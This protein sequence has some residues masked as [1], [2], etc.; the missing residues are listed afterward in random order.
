MPFFE[1]DGRK[2]YY[3]I[4]GQGD[5]VVLIHG[6]ALDSRIWMDVPQYLSLKYAVLT[7]DLR[8]HGQSYAPSTGYSYRDHVSDLNLLITELGDQKATLIGHSLGGAVAVK[9]TLQH[10]QH[11]RSL[12]LAAPHIVGYK[13][14]TA[15]PNVFRTARQIDIDQAKIQWETFRLFQR[16]DKNSPDWEVLKSCISDFPGKVWTDPE[17]GKYVD[18]SDMKMLDNLTMPVLMLCGRED[19]D[20]LPLAKLVN[21]RLSNGTLYEIPDC[22]HMIHMEKPEIFKRELSAFLKI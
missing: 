22:G 17:A 13:D 11:I 8:G 10:P 14:Y 7:Y 19:L 4:T 2:L 15:W 6:I 5:L 12:A 20:F 21:A 9:Y 1:K 18:E 16:V 3:N